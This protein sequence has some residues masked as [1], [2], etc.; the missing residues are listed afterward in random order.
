MDTRM[1]RPIF[2]TGNARSGTTLVTR[3]LDGHPSLLVFPI[4]LKYF[5]YL[6][7]PTAYPAT[8][9]STL[10]EPR[11]VIRAI[12]DSEYMRPFFG[13][14]D[15]VGGRAEVIEA[16]RQ[17]I[18]PT[19]FREE[20]LRGDDVGGHRE[21][22]ALF[23]EALLVAMGRDR[24]ELETVRC[25]EKTPMQA[26]NVGELLEWFPDAQF[27]HV[28]RN[29]YAVLVSERKR[30][31]AKAPK[32]HIARWYKAS[33]E[34]AKANA[35]LGEDVYRVVRFEDV[36]SE[37]ERTMRGVADFLG[38]TEHPIL[39][40]PTILGATWGG[41]SSTGAVKFEG[42]SKSAADTWEKE[43]LPLEVMAVNRLVSDEMREFGYAMMPQPSM[44]RLGDGFRN[45][46][47]FL[48]SMWRFFTMP[49]PNR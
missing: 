39:H 29:P 19:V 28:I 46:T 23:F 30:T 43:V 36:V 20:L 49:K 15:K 22:I 5:R 7:R 2:V 47:A 11:D 10:S 33:I 14:P 45:P 3:L 25:V 35:R 21:A 12:V 16:V 18:D 24:A 42:V 32:L 8:K 9:Q 17:A 48:K 31:P 13:E 6:D 37:P 4:E 44:L 27:I 40:T 26:E 34:H 38:L 1:V 41:N